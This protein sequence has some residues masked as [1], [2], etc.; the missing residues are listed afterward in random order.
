MGGL[1]ATRLYASSIAIVSG[2]YSLAGP[3]YGLLGMRG[4]MGQALEFGGWVMA[5]VGVLVIAHG[6]VLLSSYAAR[7]GRSSGALMV[8]W[9]T[10]MLLNQFVAGAMTGTLGPSMMR[11]M[12]WDPGMVAIAVLML[13]S[14][15]IMLR[16]P[17]DASM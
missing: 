5:V 16:R 6:V 14:G 11:Q 7:L 8:L 2:I 12:S 3:A 10:I 9:A 4:M 13:I 1:S 15:L 17:A